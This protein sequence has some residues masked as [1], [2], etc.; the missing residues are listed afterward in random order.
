M[1]CFSGGPSRL[2]APAQPP[3]PGR[4]GGAAR[5]RRGPVGLAPLPLVARHRQRGRRGADDPAG[6]R[7][8]DHRGD[9]AQPVRR[10]GARDRPAA[11]APAG[12]PDA[13]AV[14]GRHWVPRHRRGGRGQPPGRRL[15]GRRHPPGGPQ[16]PGHDRDRADLLPGYRRA[17]RVDRPARL[18]G[19]L[20]VRADRQLLRAAD[21]AGPAAGR[22][23]RVDRRHGGLRR[24]PDR[25]HHQRCPYP[26]V[27]RFTPGQMPASARCCGGRHAPLS[28]LVPP[29][30]IA[31]RLGPRR[32]ACGRRHRRPAGRRFRR[33]NGRR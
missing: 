4:P 19:H 9:N 3:C 8:R 1:G 32:P 14:R 5:L 16:R 2:A 24:R 18:H 11:A 31:W 27:R 22:P 26:P 20:P 29:L 30:A 23:G 6:L 7:R 10:A 15:P 21:L 28:V 12:W 25:V 33:R 17:D 13:G